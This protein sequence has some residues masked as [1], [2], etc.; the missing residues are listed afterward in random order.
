[1]LKKKGFK[2]KKGKWSFQELKLLKANVDR[3]LET[4]A[5]PDPV[6]I[7]LR[8]STDRKEW[9][10]WKRF[11]RENDFYRELGRG[12]LRPLKAIY[13]CALRIYDES[14]YMG[15][16]VSLSDI[17]MKKLKNWKG[18]MQCMVKTGLL[19]AGC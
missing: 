10:S 8:S 18:C 7:L 11:A 6:R 5:L 12:I 16:L 4:H 17:L 15:K 13:R 2:K 19:L 14:N 1:M 3:F 9:K